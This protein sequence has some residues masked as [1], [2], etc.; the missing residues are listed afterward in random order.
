[1]ARP[2][3]F[4]VLGIYGLSASAPVVSATDVTFNFDSHPFVNAPSNGLLTVRIETPVPSGTTG[5]LPVYFT[6]GGQNRKAATKEG[7]VSL[8]AADLLASGYYL[9][10]YDFRTGVYEAIGSIS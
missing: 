10:F 6:T 3:P 2:V 4:N 1:M 8:T 5:T 9:F 7:G